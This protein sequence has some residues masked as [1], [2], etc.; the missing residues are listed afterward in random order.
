MGLDMYL[1]RNL[2]QDG[3]VLDIKPQAELNNDA[4]A[5]LLKR[6]T[7]SNVSYLQPSISVNIAYWRKA[8]AIH[9]W[10]IS[11]CANDVDE[12][13]D[14]NVSI[15]DLHEL[16]DT[17]EKILNAPKDID[18]M[19]R[20]LPP[21]DGFFFGGT[22]LDD[23]DT[24]NSYLED[25]KYTNNILSEEFKIADEFKKYKKPSKLNPEKSFPTIYID[26]T[27]RASW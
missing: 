9:Q 13:Q 4:F 26:Y 6:A 12:C 25:V 19:K 23:A 17:C 5:K 2:N 1:S 11:H 22:D 15:K 3:D 10:F 21:Q 16:K 27:Y 14:I 20:L 7:Q 8:N 24:L 18:L